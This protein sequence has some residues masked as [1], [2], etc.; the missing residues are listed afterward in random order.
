MYMIPCA[1][2]PGG[3]LADID[4]PEHPDCHECRRMFCPGCEKWVA[5]GQGRQGDAH[6]LCNGCYNRLIGSWGRCR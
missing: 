3:E 2:G 6:A 4:L 1:C 5:R